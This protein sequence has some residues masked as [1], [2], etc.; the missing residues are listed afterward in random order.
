MK[1][2]VKELTVEELQPIISI[3]VKESLE[4]RIE[5]LQAL[6]SKDYLESIEEARKDYK[7]GRVEPFEKI[8]D[9]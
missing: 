3:T 9:V 4:E 7:E 8:V 5:G 2:K 6:S 1:T